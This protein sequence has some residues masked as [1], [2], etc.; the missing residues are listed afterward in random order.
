MNFRPLHDTPPVL[1]TEDHRAVLVAGWAAHR[2]GLFGTQAPLL[3]R[4]DAHLDFGERPRH[5]TWERAQLTDLD[6]VHALAN[7]Q[8]HDDGGWTLTAMQWGLV[9]DMATAF[10]HD[11]H[12]FPGDCGPY[13]DHRGIGHQLATWDDLATLAREPHRNPAVESL[14]RELLDTGEPSRPL[15][16]DI[17]LD[18]ATRR[19][20]SGEPTPWTPAEWDQH[21]GPD[22]VALLAS[23]FRRASLVTI[24]TEPSF[25]GGLE[26]CG[27]IAGELS[28]RLAPH[29]DWL[30][31]I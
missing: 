31:T 23:W 5:W 30:R 10:V 8:R 27:R 22:A 21:L 17:D 11:Y 20:D 2:Q 4:F 25:C 28:R 13:T 7:D 24:A 6:T 15:W 9:A 18:F 16:L 19:V 12:R 3:V 1:V 29:G 14:R 26:A